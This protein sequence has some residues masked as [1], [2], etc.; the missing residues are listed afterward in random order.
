MQQTTNVQTLALPNEGL[1]KLPAVM[2]ATGLS[3]SAV[4]AKVKTHEFP[5]PVKLGE[6]SV[7][8]PV[9]AVRT[10]IAARI[11]ASTPGAQ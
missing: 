7:A 5:A 11:K 3:R 10:W 2:N 1:A 9:D 6:R 8:W 4:Y